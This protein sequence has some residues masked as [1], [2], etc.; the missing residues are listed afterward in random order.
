MSEELEC[1]QCTHEWGEA[2]DFMWTLHEFFKNK[3]QNL[4]SLFMQLRSPYFLFTQLY[5]IPALDHVTAFQNLFHNFIIENIPVPE[6]SE[7]ANNKVIV[8][9]VSDKV[10]K[11]I[12][13][14]L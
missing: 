9:F 13:P 10:H 3:P 12:A 8:T 14:V 6:Q 7:V 5:T 2:S 11:E 4:M 1:A